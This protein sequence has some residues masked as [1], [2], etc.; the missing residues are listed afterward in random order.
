MFLITIYLPF[1]V[2]RLLTAVEPEAIDPSFPDYP[3]HRKLGGS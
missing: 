2:E 1:V 3:E